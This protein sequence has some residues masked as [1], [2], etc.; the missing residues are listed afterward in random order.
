MKILSIGNSFSCDAT[1]YLHGIA[2]ADKVDIESVNLY[3]G[4]CPLDRHFRNMKGDYRAY[5]LY[6]N[7]QATGFNMSIKEAL[8]SREWDIVTIQQ[9]SKKSFKKETYYPYAVELVEYIKELAPNAKIIMHETW[10][11]ADGSERLFKAVGSYNID[12][13]LDGVRD[14]YHAVTEELGLDGLIP[15]GET[16]GA[17]LKRGVPS[18]HRVDDSHASFGIGR[19]ALGLLWYRMLTGKSVA[20]NTY[21]DFDVEI[22]A[23][24]IAIVKEYIDTL[25]PIF[26]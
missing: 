14:T 24:E 4:G 13:M 9:A 12:D 7:G 3:I 8:L 5:E 10:A 18:V 21:D 20:E 23:E 25:K 17:V 22:P 26:E 1:R 2:H 16:L 11:Y 19:Y 6:F 15:S